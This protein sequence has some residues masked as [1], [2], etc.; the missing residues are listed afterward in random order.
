MNKAISKVCDDVLKTCGFLVN[1]AAL[2]AAA[3]VVESYV[4]GPQH[5]RNSWAGRITDRFN[6]GKNPPKS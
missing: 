1:V 3:G 4:F 2:C 5:L 6:G